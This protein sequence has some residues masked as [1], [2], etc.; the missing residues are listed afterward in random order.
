MKR[1]LNILCYCLLPFL[2]VAQNTDSISTKRTDP[3]SYFRFNYDNDFFSATDQFYTQGTYFELIS[4]FVKKIPLAHALIPLKGSVNYYGLEFEQ[5]VFTPSSIRRDT[6][7]TGDRPFAALVYL[8]QFLISIDPVKRI[9]LNTKIDMGLLGPC[10]KGKETQQNIHRWLDN[11]QPLG[12][13]YQVASD[14]MLNYNIQFE[15]GIFLRKGFEF[16]G[17]TAARAGTIYTDASAGALIRSGW[18]NSYFQNIGITKYRDA[19]TK[20][21]QAYLFC[22]GD[23]KVVGYNATLQ[24]G[25]FNPTSIYTIGP[26]KIERIVFTGSY[27]LV[28]TYKR[29]SLEYTKVYLTP[30]FYKGFEHAWGHCNI[31]FCF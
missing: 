1:L 9:R 23:A 21:F 4:P 19:S 24:G 30:E 27:G 12:W 22:R 13:Q 3:Y 26:D 25:V 31:S 20:K 2:S 17:T 11:I 8:S 16:I 6:V 14:Y 28:I 29:L 15:K 5:D 7:F 18:M 10:A